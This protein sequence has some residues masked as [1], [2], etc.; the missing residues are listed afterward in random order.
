M[1]DFQFESTPRVHYYIGRTLEAMGRK[2]EATEAYEKSIS[3]LKSLS[4]DW[5]S[6]NPENFH[7]VLSLERLGRKEEA[8]KLL[9]QLD[10]FAQT[11]LS[12]PRLPRKT[13]SRYLLGLVRKHK[14]QNAE[15]KRLMQEALSLQP[16][17]LGPRFELRGDVVD[18]LPGE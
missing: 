8:A 9:A 2:A 7:M 13:G 11:Q 3:G 15:A 17:M 16:D 14:G 4:G 18:A 5:D 12:S 1:D 6:F 10:S